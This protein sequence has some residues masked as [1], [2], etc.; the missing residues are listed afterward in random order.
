MTLYGHE[1]G[2]VAATFSPDSASLATASSDS[3][4]KVW[5]LA[6]GEP[7][8]LPGHRQG[9]EGIAFS[10]DGSR[11]AAAGQD[12]SVR[13]YALDLGDL[14]AIAQARLTRSLTTA[15]CQQYLNVEECPPGSW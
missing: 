4:A 8:T 10:P 11:L 1:S 6:G 14:V 13:V 2:V 12:G 7:V 9:V 15:E 5:P 3:T